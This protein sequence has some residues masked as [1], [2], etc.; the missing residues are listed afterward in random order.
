MR[1]PTVTYLKRREL[2]LGR[3]V[4]VSIDP[5]LAVEQ[6]VRGLGG[7]RLARWWLLDVLEQ[8]EREHPASKVA[9]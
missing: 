1:S 4:G 3:R 9:S 7:A 5:E 8:L 2:V 6:L